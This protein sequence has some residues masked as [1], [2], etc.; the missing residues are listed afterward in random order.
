M[1]VYEE[2]LAGKL[3]EYFVRYVR[4]ACRDGEE[5]V[6]RVKVISE[7]EESLLKCGQ[8]ILGTKGRSKEKSEKGVKSSMELWSGVV[9]RHREREALR[10]ENVRMTYGEVDEKAEKVARAILR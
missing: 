7:E 9:K 4:N 1:D 3:V 10:W 5:K 6:G 2:G 8:G